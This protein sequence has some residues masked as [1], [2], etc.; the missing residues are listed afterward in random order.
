MNDPHPTRIDALLARNY[1]LRVCQYAGLAFPVSAK[2]TCPPP[3][4]NSYS[5]HGTDVCDAMKGLEK[6]LGGMVIY[7]A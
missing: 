5:A 3:D 7:G 4:K 6:L 2:L 1:E